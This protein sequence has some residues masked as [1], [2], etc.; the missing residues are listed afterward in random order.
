M[1]PS[2]RAAVE[3]KPAEPEEKSARAQFERLMEQEKVTLECLM[4]VLR[5]YHPDQ[6]LEDLPVPPARLQHFLAIRLY[7]YI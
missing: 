2:P 4:T 1:K 3:M 5:C 6:E 7:K